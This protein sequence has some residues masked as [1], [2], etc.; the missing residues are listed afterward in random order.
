MRLPPAHALEA[1][2]SAARLGSFLAASRELN[3]TQ[4]AI[5]HRIKLLEGVV[6]VPLFI[7]I[8][9]HIALTPQGETYVQAV[10]DAL[11]ALAQA[12]AALKPA[13]RAARAQ[14]RICAMPAIGSR[15]LV[16]KLA[17]FQ[18]VAKG[19]D[20]QVATPYQA[21][22]LKAGAF[23]VGIRFG[24]EKLAGLASRELL[25]ENL[26]AVASAACIKRERLKRA[27]DVAG[28]LRFVHPL[29]PWPA[30]FAAAGVAAPSNATGA[31]FDD[32]ALMYEAVAAGQGVAL[33]PD[34]LL[35]AYP[36]LRK[37][38][39]VAVPGRAYYVVTRAGAP[40]RAAEQLA[41]WLVASV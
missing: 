34:T 40:S 19:V 41:Q 3:V 28:A 16:G 5:S 33:M 31:T 23:D 1:F 11:G 17:Q 25:K 18:E 24:P 8:N 39:A 2:E 38:G 36:S 15:W 4:S 12:T 20:L 9:R 6:G 30:W 27:A 37:I 21:D 22:K 29:L 32:A 13:S 14:V 26:V 35:A 10:R 7:R